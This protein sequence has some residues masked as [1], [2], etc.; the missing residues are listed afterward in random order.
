MT[1][2]AGLQIKVYWDLWLQSLGG[3][4][5]GNKPRVQDL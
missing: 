2:L 5:V 4:R 3:F 1:G